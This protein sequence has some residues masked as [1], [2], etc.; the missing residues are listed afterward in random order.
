MIDDVFQTGI[1]T[2]SFCLMLVEGQVQKSGSMVI[3]AI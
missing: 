2:G 1:T 3:P